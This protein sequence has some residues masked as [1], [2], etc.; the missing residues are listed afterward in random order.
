MERDIERTT[1]KTLEKLGYLCFK[2]SGPKGMPDRLCISPKGFVFFLEFKSLKGVEA[3]H[4][5]RIA[6]KLILN[7]VP[8]LW[9]RSKK[10][11]FDWLRELNQPIGNVNHP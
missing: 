1:V 3:E 7:G 5:K 10:A 4:Q 8:V 9:P 6:L 2:Q 11:V